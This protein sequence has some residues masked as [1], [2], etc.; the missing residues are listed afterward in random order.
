MR[1]PQDSVLPYDPGGDK[2]AEIEVMFDRIAPHYDRLTRFMSFGMDGFWRRRAVRALKSV[3]PRRIL[4]VATGTGDFALLLWR[5][6]GPDVLMGVDLS[7]HMLSIGRE[8]LRRKG[9]ADKIGLVRG[10]GKALPFDGG[11]FDAVSVAFGVRNF[12]NLDRAL[13][14]MHRVLTPGGRLVILELSTPVRWPMKQLFI[15]YSHTVIPLLARLFGEDK[16]AYAYLPRSIRAFPQAEVMSQRIARAG[17]AQV[18]FRRLTLGL[19]T[20]YLAQK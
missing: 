17:F 3:N 20:L 4:D 16:S 15:F 1:Y 13:R 10:D 18:S 14:D 8:K 12:K 11:S 19:C 6:I 9:L 5:K 2:E 7:E